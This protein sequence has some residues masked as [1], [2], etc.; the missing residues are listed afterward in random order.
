MPATPRNHNAA[1][2]AALA[3][4][5]IGAAFAPASASPKSEEFVK[6]A[7]AALERQDAEAALIQLKNAV[8]A[9]A[10]DWQARRLLGELYLASGR[11]DVALPELKAVYENAPDDEAEISLAR[12]HA[13][14]GE[15][16]KALDVVSDTA[17]DGRTRRRKLLL[18]AD[19]LRR[20]GAL[21]EASAAV[22]GVLAEDPLNTYANYISAL[23]YERRGAILKAQERLDTIVQNDLN[24]ADA[25]TMKS[26]I[27]NAAGDYGASIEYADRALEVR[28]DDQAASILRVEGLIRNGRLD[29]A[30]EAISSISR[31]DPDDPRAPYLRTLVA[32]AE[33][34]F[35][36]ADRELV[37]VGDLLE[38]APNGAM[39]AGFV[40]YK[41]GNLAQA[42]QILAR[43]RADNPNDPGPAVLLASV[44]LRRDRL[45]A[46]EGTLRAVLDASP[47]TASARQLL[48]SV[49]MRQGRPDAAV[50]EIRKAA[51][52]GYGASTQISRA[53][54]AETSPDDLDA[55]QARALLVL[56]YLG[57]EQPDEALAE[58]QAMAEA[59][60]DSPVALNLLGSVHIA[61]DEFE[62]A[63]AALVRAVENEPAFFAAIVNLDRLDLRSGDYQAIEDRLQRARGA[64]PGSTAIALRL[65]RFLASRGRTDEA[66]A[67]LS[68]SAGTLND[69]LAALT[70]LARLENASGAA[71][72]LAKTAKRLEGR[73][74]QDG[75]E[76]VA[77]AAQS[78]EEAGVLEDAARLYE[79][80]RSEPEYRTTAG[81]ALARVLYADGATD[82]SIGVLR[83]MITAAPE[84]AELREALIRVLIADERYDAAGEAVA[85]LAAVDADSAAVYAARTARA[86]GDAAGG[87]A[88]LAA[89]FEARPNSLLARSLMA[90]RIAVGDVEGGLAGMSE[91]IEAHP[92]DAEALTAYGTALIS[93]DRPDDA[94]R[95]LSAALSS[96]G[97]DPALLN[98]TAWVR[99]SI[100]RPGALTLARKARA[101]APGS[102]EIADTLGWI[103]YS[104][105]ETEEGLGLL[106][107]AWAAS[108]DSPAIGYRLASAL[109]A[110]GESAEAAIVLDAVLAIEAPFD[111]RAE[112]EALR[113]GL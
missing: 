59:D 67:L 91:W 76:A 75:L 40:K 111:E 64:A 71:D 47:D 6:K 24:F 70:A 14:L 85:E 20:T 7:R 34:D 39:L 103:L 37:Q 112:A 57:S 54:G 89:A 5:A 97:D 15:Y 77:A 72:A 32:V 94:E 2:L 1:L 17:A 33:G 30:R 61:R 42:E 43:Y 88:A 3:A 21:D 106:R 52:S 65:A 16:E 45:D 31:R 86:R 11:P 79:R 108:P 63:R 93:V 36:R 82:R 28:P 84:R 8:Q 60:P 29:E 92:D 99:Q 46:A 55:T 44:Q 69:P 80:L 48:A 74:A 18:R 23:I 56:D 98:N 4:F 90:Y 87:E 83:E 10:R 41:T 68:E 78:Y 104:Q 95:V 49:L 58:A 53:L 22:D 100:G 107:E 102:P 50:A 109:A 12:A 81:M 25:W 110:E 66:R 19:I 9:D 113:R 35:E 105:G 38:Q 96:A 73:S 13:S 27:A 62:E 101:L 26:R 51:E